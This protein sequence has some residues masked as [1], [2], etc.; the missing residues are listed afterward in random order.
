MSK[1]NN[2]KKADSPNLPDDTATRGGKKA[3]IGSAD[4][5]VASGD[6][7][8]GSPLQIKSLSPIQQFC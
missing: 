7:S 2:K 1:R 5:A 4:E 3:R 8:L 6:F